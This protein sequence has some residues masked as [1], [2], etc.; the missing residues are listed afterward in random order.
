LIKLNFNRTE[1]YNFK[2]AALLVLL[3]FIAGIIFL[4]VQFFL[5]KQEPSIYEINGELYII[6]IEAFGNGTVTY[7]LRNDGPV[8]VNLTEVCITGPHNLTGTITITKPKLEVITSIRQEIPV[9]RDVLVPITVVFS[10]ENLDFNAAY[11]FGCKWT[12]MTGQ[13]GCYLYPEYYFSNSEN[14]G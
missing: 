12:T 5:E 6:D 8:P 11:S 7:Y 4:E 10:T 14:N 13:G 2:V 3:V 1:N 9:N